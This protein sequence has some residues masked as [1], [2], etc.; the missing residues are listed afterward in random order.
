ME[1]TIKNQ[2]KLNDKYTKFTWITRYYYILAILVSFTYLF[3]D[4]IRV[5]V[6]CSA[7]MVMILIDYVISKTKQTKIN[8]NTTTLLV[9]VYVLYNLFSILIGV[10]NGYSVSI[11]IREFSN[12][13]LPIIF[14]FVALN[15]NNLEE[16][17]FVKSFMYAALFLVL[18]GVFMYISKPTI[19]FAY[20]QRTILHYNQKYYLA[21]PRMY[22]FAGSVAVGSIAS[23]GLAFEMGYLISKRNTC[24]T[25]VICMVLLIGIML[26]M[27]RSAIVFAMLI[28][29]IMS[30]SAFKYKHG[31][32]RRILRY[33]LLLIVLITI[34]AS[35]YPNLSEQMLSRISSMTNAINERNSDWGYVWKQ[36]IGTLIGSGLG[37]RGH[38]GMGI[39]DITIRD[40]NYFKMIFEIGLIG[41][42]LF[43]SIMVLTIIKGS[44][45]LKEN[46]VYFCIVLGI[47][48]Q[49][50]GTNTFTFQLVVPIFWF[51]VGRINCLSRNKK[52]VN[53]TRD[54]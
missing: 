36:G 50:I 5:G 11:G 53:K 14:Y 47:S 31:A 39:S 24:R 28:I 42:I 20:L 38:R 49:A 19:Y 10:L 54:E 13:L 34:S 2:T 21:A 35:A 40:G 7:I 16:S 22:S 3:W 23:V 29:M 30:I 51:A 18:V 6:V 37:T 27:Q 32:F 44:K 48:L 8:F 4:G 43:V 41:T 17:K 15:M 1:Q 33:V 52:S 45:N 12:G 25:V 9:I 46:A 26:T